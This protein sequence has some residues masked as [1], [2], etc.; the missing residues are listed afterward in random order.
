M[1]N[2]E[3]TRHQT[4]SGPFQRRHR[5]E[6]KKTLR[7]GRIDCRTSPIRQHKLFLVKRRNTHT[8]THT[9]THTDSVYV[10]SSIIGEGC[11]WSRSGLSYGLYDCIPPPKIVLR[12]LARLAIL[13]YTTRTRKK[14]RKKTPLTLIRAAEARVLGPREGEEKNKLFA[15]IPRESTSLA[16]IQVHIRA[17]QTKAGRKGKGKRE[18][19]SDAASLP[20]RLLRLQYL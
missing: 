14:K 9:H 8:H 6:K 11:S 15:S 16:I 19:R 2:C 20:T 4:F 7:G 5:H 1:V 3:Y 12:S 17:I 18:E 10:C 13:L